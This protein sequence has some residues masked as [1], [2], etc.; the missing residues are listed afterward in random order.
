[1]KA[2]KKHVTFSIDIELTEELEQLRNYNKI[3]SKSV[4][5]NEAIKKLLKE[6]FKNDR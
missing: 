2:R 3:V 4:F 6:E 1:M 5:V